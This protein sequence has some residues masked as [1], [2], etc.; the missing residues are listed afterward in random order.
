MDTEVPIYIV[1]T[2]FDGWQQTKNCLL[3]LQRS[4]YEN[5]KVVV[6][7]HGLTDE[8]ALGIKEFPACTRI[9]AESTLWW[10]GAS[11]VGIRFAIESGSRHVM[12]LNNDCYVT[13][14]TIEHLVEKVADTSKLIVAPLQVSAHSDE[15]L[16]GRVTTCFTLGF[17][18]LVLPWMKDVPGKANGLLPTRM[19][20]G[21]RGVLIPTEVFNVVGLFDEAYLPHYGADHDFY[22]RCRSAD[23]QLAI[24]PD[25]TVS[26]DET[27]TTVAR[28]LQDMTF[29]QF[30]DSFQ[31]IRSHR[32]FGMLTTLFKRYYPVKGLYF[33]GVFLNVSRYFFSYL[34]AR[35]IGRFAMMRGQAVGKK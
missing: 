35:L 7:D 26:I 1:I 13:A 28:D 12:L 34:L 5:V 6:V 17:P 29:R 31:D 24:A 3:A 8:T 23:V 33:I 30:L 15:V 22:L 27:R 18:T 11:N 21:G 9:P 32:N 19:I 16:A 2:D 10:T 4:T 14:T 25:I 20:V